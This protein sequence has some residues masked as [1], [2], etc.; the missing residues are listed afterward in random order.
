MSEKCC[1]TCKWW[2]HEYQLVG[3]W[4][5]TTDVGGPCLYP[6]EGL[7]IPAIYYRSNGIAS[8]EGSDCPTY[9]ARG[10]RG[11]ESSRV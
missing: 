6:V 3:Y 4:S 7:R 8:M 2:K 11:D 5:N 9:Q 1:G 10:G